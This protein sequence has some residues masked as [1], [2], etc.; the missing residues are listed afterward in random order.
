[1]G[2]LKVSPSYPSAY[3]YMHACHSA[4]GYPMTGPN[5]S[6]PGY[7]LGM[8]ANTS[9]TF[10]EP[11]A[12]NPLFGELF[13]TNGVLVATNP[14][15]ISPFG[16]LGANSP[17]GALVSGD[18]ST[19]TDSFGVPAVTGDNGLPSTSEADHVTTASPW[20]AAPRSSFLPTWLASATIKAPALGNLFRL[21]ARRRHHVNE[22]ISITELQRPALAGKSIAEIRAQCD[23]FVQL[24]NMPDAG[25]TLMIHGAAG[26]IA[27]MVWHTATIMCVRARV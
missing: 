7:M 18:A 14:N 27:G 25:E 13:A 15:S 2:V 22:A 17:I 6:T 16:E 5:P 20:D 11:V 24:L 12:T 8:L 21:R 23:T 26:T 3:D 10:G 4:P 19:F 1:M 9:T